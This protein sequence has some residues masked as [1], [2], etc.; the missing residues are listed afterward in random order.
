MGKVHYVKIHEAKTNLSRLLAAVESGDEVVVQRGNT[1][2]AKIVA[3]SPPAGK[4]QLGTLKGK[5]WMSPDFD[6][7]LAEFAD[8]R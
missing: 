8:Y 4:R 3:Y 6:E 7:P 2:I 1:P 5:I